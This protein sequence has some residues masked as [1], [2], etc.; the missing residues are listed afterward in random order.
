MAESKKEAEMQKQIT[1]ENLLYSTG[2][3]TQCSLVTWMGGKFK[4]KK[5]Y[6]CVYVCVCVYIYIY[7][8]FT[9]L[10]SRKEHNIAKQLHT[11]KKLKKKK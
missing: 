10:Y 6:M 8:C 2:N 9:L 7:I 5:G 4:N 1:N 11:N 3:S